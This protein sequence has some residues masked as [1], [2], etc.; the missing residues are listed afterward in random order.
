MRKA[1]VGTVPDVA[2]GSFS[3]WPSYQLG[4]LMMTLIFVLTYLAGSM[5][6]CLD[7]SLSNFVR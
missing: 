5:M 1:A 2:K 4:Y 7:F 6:C 3:R